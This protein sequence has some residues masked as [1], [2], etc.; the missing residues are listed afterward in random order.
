MLFHS[1]YFNVFSLYFTD[2]CKSENGGCAQLCVPVG[3]DKRKCQCNKGFKL[4]SNDT[5][6]TACEDINECLAPGTCS[7]VCKN[8]KGSYKCECF[9]GYILTSQHYCKAIGDERPE[10]ILSVETELRRYHLDT[11][12]YSKLLEG[13][14]TSATAVDFDKREQTIY[15]TDTHEKKIFS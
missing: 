2:P 8:L 6:E 10:L 14:V 7:Q 11:Y 1:L 9:P 15:Y 5:N 4:V 3:L 12:H 13:K